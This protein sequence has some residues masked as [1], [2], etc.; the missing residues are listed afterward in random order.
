MKTIFH[1]GQ[2]KTATTSIQ[3][4]LHKNRAQLIE[5]EKVYYPSV[6]GGRQDY[7]HYMLNVVCLA[8][9]RLSFKKEQ[10]IK[11][12]G[13]NAVDS[14]LT[15]V[16]LDIQTAY[17][18]AERRGCEY[19]LFSNEGL[20]TLN[21]LEEY[22]NLRNLVSAY[23]TH[24]T[25][26]CCFRDKV[27][28]RESMLAQIRKAG[29]KPSTDKDHYLYLEWDSFYFDYAKKRE[30]LATVFDSQIYYSYRSDSGVKGFLEALK[31][32]TI[33]C[34]EERLNVSTQ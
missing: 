22:M 14:V 15:Q 28:Y 10:L 6:I 24:T 21:S 8:Q 11:T 5:K 9:E 33:S 27:D 29:Q 7:S 13:S 3:F 16:K 34:E 18:E 19:V 17:E 25:A 4:F 1:I 20:Y 26:V 30:L 31:M 12:M 23:S 2:H 32:N